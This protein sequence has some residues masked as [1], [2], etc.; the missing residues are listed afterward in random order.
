M[1]NRVAVVVPAHD[2]EALLPGCLAA[3]AVAAAEVD[4]PVSITVV[5]DACSDRTA[6]LAAAAGARVV[7]VRARNV[8][9]ARATGFAR[10]TGGDPRGLWLATTDAD[11]RVPPSWLSRQLA[12]ADRVDVV[13]GAVDVVDWSEWP[14]W[15]PE[16]Y[17]AR[18]AREPDHVHG[19][20]LGLSAE[21]YL[22]VRGFA[23]LAS[24]ED[25]HLVGLLR[26]AGYRVAHPTDDP[27]LTSA[28]RSARCAGGFGAH[29][30]E[31]VEPDVA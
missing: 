26:V 21:A 16:V 20:N 7:A 27:V 19:A 18:Y 23:A 10:V 31:L 8:G 2:E 12:L 30:G 11:S 29:L 14:N 17:A 3:L 28:R 25:N 9:V 1:L 5:A 15:L 13:A 22:A 4:A 6:D 24:G